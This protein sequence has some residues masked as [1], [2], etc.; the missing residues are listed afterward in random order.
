MSKDIYTKV[1][2]AEELIGIRDNLKALSSKE[3]Y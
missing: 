2:R 3:I 1:G